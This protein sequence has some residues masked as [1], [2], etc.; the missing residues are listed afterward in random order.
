MKRKEIFHND[1]IR[2]VEEDGKLIVV[3]KRPKDDYKK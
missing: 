1:D 3:T 2:L